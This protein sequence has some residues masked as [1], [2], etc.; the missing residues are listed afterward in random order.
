MRQ[1]GG[2]IV[3]ESAPGRGTTF[4][5]YLPRIHASVFPTD[6]AS[7]P[8]KGRAA[9]GTILLAE[10]NRD[11]RD[12]VS[13]VLE[14]HGYEVVVACDGVQALELYKSIRPD[15]I[16]TVT[17]VVMPNVGGSDLARAI[18]NMDPR[19]KVL[20]ISGYA[21]GSATTDILREPGTAFLQKPFTS[22]ALLGKLNE[23]LDL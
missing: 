15:V 7:D 2:H 11:V 19:A 17:D 4:R 20:F 16:A 3:V 18:R 14:D 6:P 22:P 9:P 23:L 10:D 1:S 13:R 21:E 12:L 8:V 5:V